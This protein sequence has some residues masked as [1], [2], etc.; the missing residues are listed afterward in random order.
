MNEKLREKCRLTDAQ[1]C[2]NAELNYPSDEVRRWVNVSIKVQLDKAEPMIRQ[3]E[4]KHIGGMLL[5]LVGNA[6]LEDMGVGQ[7]LGDQLNPVLKYLCDRTVAKS[8]E[9]KAK[10]EKEG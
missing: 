7:K 3:D 6:T 8:E 5:S 9:L 10:V 4:D 1:K 2:F